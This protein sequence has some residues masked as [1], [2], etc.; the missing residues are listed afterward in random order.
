MKPVERARIFRFVLDS[1][2]NEVAQRI[3]ELVTVLRRMTDI[4]ESVYEAE[5]H[6]CSPE[7]IEAAQQL[8]K[9][10]TS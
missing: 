6:Y 2:Q 3:E 5:G 9:K 7:D 8:I 4:A 10:V 1:P